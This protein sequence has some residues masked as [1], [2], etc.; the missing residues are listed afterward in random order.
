MHH[1][2]PP[3]IES[4]TSWAIALISLAIIAVVFGSP[5][6]VVVALKDIA[7]EFGG[8]RSVPSFAS[9]L[10]WLGTAV[11]GIG[12]GLIAARLGVR[13]T[14]SIGAC[15]CA[16]GLGLSTLG[17]EWQLQL[18]HGLFLGLLGIGAIN[19]PLYVYISR[20]FDRRRGSALALISSG[21]YVAGA[22]WPPI[23]EQVIA[24]IGW[25]Q[26]MLL[27]ALVV[28]VL[29]LAAT[30]LRPPPEPAADPQGVRALTGTN[31]VLGW[32]PGV[33]FALLC[34]AIFLCCTT[35]AMP[36]GHLVA[37]CSDL[38][39]AASRGAAMLSLLL[40]TAFVSRQVW[41]LIADRIGGLRTVQIGSAA[42]A[43]A[44]SGFLLTQNE[45]AL[46]AVAA[47][48]GLGF[49]GLIPAN[50]LAI[51]ELFPVAQASWRIPTL[52]LCS[53]AGMGTGVWLAGILY[54]QFGSYGP[55][56]AFGLALNLFNFC[57]ISLL[58]LRQTLQPVP[59]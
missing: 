51:R 13:L 4:R 10:V 44:M 23:F 5:W 11:G 7:A 48:F 26:T 45:A 27:Y 20:W 25:R 21:S 52:L 18:G 22:I 30:F 6:I 28:V 54:D 15:A 12:M 3:T 46:F 41:G 40:G 38:G 14:T 57:I 29:P 58:V 24:R 53:G 47:A 50:V 43:I 59:A 35:M 9:F 31:A 42:Q 8:V 19:A 49:S 39:I 37:L 56:F 34:A 16:A 36:Q 17:A 33:V 1:G 55:A 32:P 2:L